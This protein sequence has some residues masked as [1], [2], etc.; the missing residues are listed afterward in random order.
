MDMTDIIADVEWSSARE[1]LF[2]LTL[3]ETLIDGVALWD[4]EDRLL[5]T[6]AAYRRMFG[7]AASALV[8]GVTYT[9]ALRAYANQEHGNWMPVNR[10]AWIADRVWNHKNPSKPFEALRG[11]KW[12]RFYEVYLPNG[13]LLSLTSDVTAVKVQQGGETDGTEAS[14]EELLASKAQ[15]DLLRLVI[16]NLD[17]GI[18]VFEGDHRLVLWNPR[19]VELFDFPDSLIQ[20]GTPANAF[21]RYLAEHGMYGDVDIEEAVAKRY[22]AVTRAKSSRRDISYKG[23]T[24]D[25]TSR[26][27]PGGGLIFTY[28]DLT[29]RKKA[30][31]YLAT[32]KEQAESANL[33]KS[34]FLANMSHELRTPLNAII[35]FSQVMQDQTFGPLGDARYGE[36]LSDIQGSASHLLALINDVLDVS[37]IEVGRMELDIQPVGLA[38][39]ADAAIMFVA[40][41]AGKAGVRLEHG[42]AGSDVIILADSRR[43]T[44]VLAN[45]LSNAI[46]F[47]SDGGTVI[48]SASREDDGGVKIRVSDNGIGMS[49]EEVTR[50]QERFGQVETALNRSHEGTGL[51]LPLSRDL[52]ES[53]GGKMVIESTPGQGTT[54]TVRFPADKVIDIT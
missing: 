42:L 51:G 50:A 3:A 39:A 32:A 28:T 14:L 54:V 23:R 46:K 1:R 12:F 6:N 30:E 17:Q 16:E 31:D 38:D 43:L 10:D 26:L 36:Y 15:S 18:A 20:M 47:T 48:L 22:E 34:D 53:H 45:L 41:Q 35:G 4:A 37:A 44:Q 19:F 27:I 49:A 24:L 21:F 25:I 5:Y 2:F 33:A 7:E 40:P 13:E 29:E 52:V 8:P 11:E 9:E